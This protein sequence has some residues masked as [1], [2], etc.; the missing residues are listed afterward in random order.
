MGHLYTLWGV[1]GFG[2]SPNRKHIKM[3]VFL[4]FLCDKHIKEGSRLVTK[5]CDGLK[6]P[7][8]P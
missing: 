3:S 1:Y 2:R 6:H 7:K 8:A 5:A 4:C